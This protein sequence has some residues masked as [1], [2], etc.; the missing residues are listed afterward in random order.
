MRRGGCEVD[1][2]GL[3]ERKDRKN[4][5]VSS[6]TGGEARCKDHGVVSDK[7]GEVKWETTG[8][9]RRSGRARR[10]RGGESREQP[11]RDDWRPEGSRRAERPPFAVRGGTYR[12]L[13]LRE[14]GGR[15][16]PP[17][18]STNEERSLSLGKVS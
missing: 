14:S 2:R 7:E 10:R 15:V 9:E 17:R 5:E 6:S 8:L 1:G 16:Q 12:R 4:R 3:E 18:G 13:E 11:I